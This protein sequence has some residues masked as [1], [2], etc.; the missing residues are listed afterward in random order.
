MGVAAFVLFASVELLYQLSDI[1]VR[2]RVG[3]LKLFE[4]IYYNLPYFVSMGIPVG[5]LFSIFWVLSQLYSSKE[6][7]AMLVHGIPS[8][9]LV[10]P[11]FLLSVL[12]G[13]FAFYLNDQMVPTFNHKAMKTISKYVYKRPEISIRENVL[14]KIDESQY[15]FVKRYDQSSGILYDVVL[16]Q[17]IQG[18]ERIITAEKVQ[19]DEGKW[20]LI[21]G[22]M[23]VTDKDGFLKFDVNFSKI[24]LDL[25]DDLESLMRVGKS[26]RDMTGDEL[27][28]KI[29]TFRKLG[30]DPSPWIVELHGRYANSVGPFI[31]TILGVPLSLLFG[32]KSKSWSVIFTFAIVILY[33][34][35]GAWISAMGK[36]NLLNP[37]LAAWF[38]NLVF[39][40]VGLFLFLMLDTPFA[41][42]L[43]ELLSKFMIVIFLI[44]IST[45]VFSNTITLEASN[46]IYKDNFIH[47]KENVRIFWDE[48]ILTSSEAT[49][50]VENSKA[51]ILEAYGNVKF[52]KEGK[53]YNAKYVKYFFSEK[54]SYAVRV[55]GVE[56]YKSKKGKVDLYF[57]AE[58][59][60][61]KK[62]YI[63]L[64]EAY[65]TT[66]ELEKPHYRVEAL[67]V[68]IYED[69]YLVA[70]NSMLFL[71]EFPFFPY[72]VYFS[73]LSEDS[74]SPFSFSFSIDS[75]LNFSTRQEYSL[76]VDNYL[77]STTFETGEGSNLIFTILD[78]KEKIFYIDYGKKYLLVDLGYLEYNTR[79]D[80]KTT[81]LKL[82][83]FPFYYSESLNT[84]W[85]K[86]IGVSFKTKS[87]FFDLN[88]NRNDKEFSINNV[89][90]LSGLKKDLDFTELYIS[91]FRFIS[92][93]KK[94]SEEILFDETGSYNVSFKDKFYTTNFSG[95][96]KNESYVSKIFHK[97]N[98]PFEYKSDFFDVNFE[99]NFG[100]SCYN[101]LTDKYYLRLGLYDAYKLSGNLKFEVLE[102]KPEYGYRK[103]FRDE[104]TNTEYNKFSIRLYVKSK[105][106]NF[107]LTQGYDFFYN[108]MLNDKI[109]VKFSWN[110]FFLQADTEYDFKLKK[111]NPSSV[112]ISYVDSSI[113]LNYSANFK[114]YHMEQIPVREITHLV[115]FQKLKGRVRQSIEENYIKNAYFKGSFFVNKCENILELNYLKKSKDSDPSYTLNYK[116]KSGDDTF[117]LGYK[118]NYKYLEIGVNLKSIDPGLILDAVYN[119]ETEKFKEL[120]ISILKRLHHWMFEFSSEFEFNDDGIFDLDD[121]NKLSVL[122]YIIEF[123]DKFF[124]WDFKE[125]KPNIGLF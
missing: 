2:H 6:I 82:T 12:F 37:V 48:N 101:A 114:Y 62:G 115:T 47:A 50:L 5:V 98:L 58:N 14:T 65:I 57:G 69:R 34:G 72:P 31:I 86:R 100:L 15:F 41:Y 39:I 97:F 29:K 108:K 16:F 96:L 40:S 18:E 44:V 22:K 4:L 73:S 122:F 81:N 75:K 28:N 27:K 61:K 11:F 43:R 88:L 107:L 51:K 64:N 10:Y 25:K 38:P 24:S 117:L 109:M 20:F 111:L 23:Y 87:Y 33:Q 77:L 9:K 103:N 80:L 55:R 13:L 113:P 110:K 42:K 7:T 94:I 118:S 104:A 56:K 45:N 17:H 8:R 1:I 36:E 21:N 102:L 3:I 54:K 59:F 74:K 106:L 83:F 91:N 67:D 70:E 49:I 46:V 93:V 71:F 120:K 116:L 52:N 63:N 76:Y 121:V 99:Y 79:W 84:L 78:G 89:F 92:S 26:P 85:F 112:K 124:G 123:E 53:V 66:C 68:Y 90:S 119:F 19:K 125:N 95:N 60:E 35:S 30:V 32:L 105:F